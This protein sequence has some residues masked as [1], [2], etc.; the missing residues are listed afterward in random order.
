ME[1]LKQR[2]EQVA[3]SILEQQTLTDNLD[4]ASATVLLNWSLAQVKMIVAQTESLDDVA[5]EAAM[6]DQLK[7][8]RTFIQRKFQK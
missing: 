4:D 6:P 1:I 5:A 2:Q 3:A 8:L 7:A